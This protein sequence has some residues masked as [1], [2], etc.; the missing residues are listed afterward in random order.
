[1]KKF[2]SKFGLIRVLHFH[3]NDYFIS[4]LFEISCF[5]HTRENS[6]W[7]NSPRLHWSAGS[8]EGYGSVLLLRQRQHFP[9]A[10]ARSSS[11][12]PAPASTPDR[13]NKSIALLAHLDNDITNFDWLQRPLAWSR[14]RLWSSFIH[15]YSPI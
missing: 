14:C 5:S 10:L 13:F 11:S 7:V 1:M 9:C 3:F 8:G 2:C 4:S 6:A 12:W 15:G